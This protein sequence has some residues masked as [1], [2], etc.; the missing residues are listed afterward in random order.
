MQAGKI[1]EKCGTQGR[2][3]KAGW[4]LAEG[5]GKGM[6]SMKISLIPSFVHSYLAVTTVASADE[7]FLSSWEFQKPH[8]E[9]LDDERCPFTN[10]IHF[11]WKD[12]QGGK[13]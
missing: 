8:K 6:C 2:S 3:L 4:Q 1:W 12:R 7:S 10:S 9:D 5:G 13:R 11:Y